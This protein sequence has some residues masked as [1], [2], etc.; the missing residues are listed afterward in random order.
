MHLCE[1]SPAYLLIKISHLPKLLATEIT[2]M[3]LLS[4]VCLLMNNKYFLPWESLFIKIT[5]SRL[6]STMDMPMHKI[7]HIFINWLSQWH[8]THICALYDQYCNPIFV[9]HCRQSLH[10]LNWLGLSS[11][12]VKWCITKDFF[13]MDCTLHNTLICFFFNSSDFYPLWNNCL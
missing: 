5:M 6:L 4:R 12:W 9:N 11:M 2:V 8:S 10:R 3:W 13:C 1:F 7:G